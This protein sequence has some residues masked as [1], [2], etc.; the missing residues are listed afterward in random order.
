MGGNELRRVGGGDG[1]RGE[2]METREEGRGGAVKK[3]KG[4]RIRGGGCEG[5]KNWR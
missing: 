5:V 4:G 1:G 2:Q 3:R